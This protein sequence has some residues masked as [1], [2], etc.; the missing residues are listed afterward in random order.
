MKEIG[1]S[2]VPML[3]KGYFT[4]NQLKDFLGQSKYGSSLCEGIY[5]RQDEKEFLKY[6]AKIVR[7]DFQQKI[8]VHWT[9][10]ELRRNEIKY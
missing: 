1:I 4:L 8:E 5:I 10:R 3:G 9:K 6:R 7:K 2:I